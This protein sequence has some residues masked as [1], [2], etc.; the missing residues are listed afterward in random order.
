MATKE[1]AKKKFESST[2]SPLAVDKMSLKLGTYLGASK[3]AI[4]G[5]TPVKNWKEGDK[6]EWFDKCY[7][8]MKIAYG[9]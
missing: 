9:V 5:S 6:G 2:E 3:S 7:D 1:T 8:N 4:E